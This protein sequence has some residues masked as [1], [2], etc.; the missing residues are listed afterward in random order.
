MLFKTLNSI[1]SV[2]PS[3]AVVG[4]YMVTKLY[5]LEGDQKQE[6]A[7]NKEGQVRYVDSLPDVVVGEVVNFGTWHTSS[8]VEILTDK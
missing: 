3:K 4:Q 2:E 6:I 1:Y 8:V 5:H 7:F